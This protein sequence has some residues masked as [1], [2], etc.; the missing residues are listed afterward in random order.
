MSEDDI[1]NVNVTNMALNV[2]V[3][4]ID[5]PF[6]DM[7]WLTAKFFLA[8]FLLFSVPFLLVTGVTNG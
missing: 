1:Q 3:T 4:T 8:S 7:F 2:R 6:K 5:I